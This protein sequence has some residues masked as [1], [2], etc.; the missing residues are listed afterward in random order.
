VKHRPTLRS[1]TPGFVIALAAIFFG[2]AAYITLAE[3]PARL[4]LSPGPMLAQWKISFSSGIVIQGALAILTALAALTAGWLTRDWRWFAG[5]L[6]MLAN[7]PWTLALIAPINA[8]LLGT[9]PDAAGAASVELIQ[10]WGQLHTVR[11]GISLTALALF[12][13]ASSR[14]HSGPARA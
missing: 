13:W 10:R 7:W 14:P 8:A 2:I 5:G 6:L 11:A 9:A 1:T 3:Q 12:L 4:A